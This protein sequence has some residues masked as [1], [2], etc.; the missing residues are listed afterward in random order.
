MNY[1]EWFR[2]GEKA[3]QDGREDDIAKHMKRYHPNG[4]D[5]KTDRCILV[6]KAKRIDGVV[7]K[8]APYGKGSPCYYEQ[9]SNGVTLPE[10]EEWI[11]ENCGGN[12]KCL[13]IKSVSDFE[14]TGLNETVISKFVDNGEFPS[15]ENFNMTCGKF[16]GVAKDIKNRFPSIEFDIDYFI[17]FNFDGNKL[18]NSSRDKRYRDVSYVGMMADQNLL[19]YPDGNY[20]KKGRLHWDVIR[21]ELGHSIVTESKFS[22]AEN[23]LD[24]YAVS[25]GM[26]KTYDDL[27]STVS[28]NSAAII[29]YIAQENPSE[30]T[31]EYIR[32]LDETLAEIFSV[33]TDPDY[34]EG[35]MP[36][37][38][39]EIGKLLTASSKGKTMK[40]KVAFDSMEDNKE[41]KRREDGLCDKVDGCYYYAGRQTKYGH[42]DY[43][44]HKWMPASEGSRELKIQKAFIDTVLGKEN[45]ECGEGK[46]LLETITSRIIPR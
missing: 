46:E 18:G 19:S 42:W 34:K 3:T 36:K 39:E 35:A 5:P 25:N 6:D 4:F 16:Y 26:K 41:V 32:L 7:S 40:E 13:L 15:V 38:F 22:S 1:W 21:H 43:E 20:Y 9:Y 37:Q 33:Y 31:P 10:M 17:P 29:L 27:N 28:P 44:N 12:T 30:R 23:I 2:N 8:E 11:K 14:R 24:S 45:D